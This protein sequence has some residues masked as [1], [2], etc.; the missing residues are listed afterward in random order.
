MAKK[1]T[2]KELREPDEF[3]TLSMKVFRYIVENRKKL[4]LIG[5]VL[6]LAA[7]AAAGVAFYNKSYETKAAALYADAAVTGT[8]GKEQSNPRALEMYEELIRFYPRSTVAPLAYYHLGNLLYEKGEQERAIAAYE[9]F[10]GT[11]GEKDRLIVSLAWYG[12]GYCHEDRK[13]Y[14]KAL[15]AF[16]QAAETS[17]ETALRPVMERN[18]G[19]IYEAVGN[20]EK[21]REHYEKALSKPG[22]PLM[23]RYLRTIL[24]EMGKSTE[25]SAEK[26]S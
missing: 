18:I 1:L 25:R 10:I 11:A 19:R 13:E 2:K 6:L 24:A 23:E 4:Y 9:K 5:V 15:E 14:P 22:D 7:A 20:V 16:E 21:A 3:Q 17:G 12:I 8:P 26:G